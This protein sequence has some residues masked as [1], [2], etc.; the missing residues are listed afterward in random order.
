[1]KYYVKNDR[2]IVGI[3]RDPESYTHRCWLSNNGIRVFM[4][5]PFSYCVE[6]LSFWRYIL[7]DKNNI[8][9]IGTADLNNFK[10][11]EYII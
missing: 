4:N 11:K 8:D 3:R 9:Y 5:N 1:M 10:I 2:Q 7:K 6:S